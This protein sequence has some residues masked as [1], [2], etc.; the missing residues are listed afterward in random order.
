MLINIF[1][2]LGSIAVIGSWA[3]AVVL[4]RSDKFAGTT[5]EQAPASTD[6]RTDVLAGSAA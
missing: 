3:V 5:T 6:H 2:V 4:L 1:L